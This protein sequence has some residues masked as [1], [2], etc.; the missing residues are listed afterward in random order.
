[1]R[2]IYTVMKR[3]IHELR[4]R[5]I[6]ITHGE[7]SKLSGISS[8]VFSLYT[9]HTLLIVTIPVLTPTWHI[10][11]SRRYVTGTLFKAAEYQLTH[12]AYGQFHIIQSSMNISAFIMQL[13]TVKHKDLHRLTIRSLFSHV[14]SFSSSIMSNAFSID[15]HNDTT[16][17]WKNIR[18]VA[19]NC[20]AATLS[21]Y[22]NI[23]EN[24]LGTN[25]N[26][27]INRLIGVG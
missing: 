21:K 20:F 27:S 1:M 5:W 8:R 10:K 16:L 15:L 17:R 25:L 23:Y 14:R 26:V 9:C 7:P 4:W 6:C 13:Y 19:W 11:L 2:H 24:S 22:I 3:L 18:H 12:F